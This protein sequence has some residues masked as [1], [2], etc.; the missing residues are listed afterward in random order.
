[1]TCL[2]PPNCLK[3]GGAGGSLENIGNLGRHFVKRA[4]RRSYGR[5]DSLEM[6][7]RM[8]VIIFPRSP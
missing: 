8:Q 7:L 6:T 4:E 5:I 2:T 1:M 3:Q